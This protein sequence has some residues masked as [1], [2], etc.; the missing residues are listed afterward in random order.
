MIQDQRLNHYLTAW[1]LSTPQL[2]TQTVTSH[3]FTVIHDAETVILK[4]LSPC[5]TDEQRGALALRYF[6]GHG[7][8]RLLRHDNGAQLIEYASGV[9]LVTLVERGEDENATR[10]IAQVIQQLHSV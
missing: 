3:I 8:T 2:L 1:N 5:E 4:L 9:E 7:A 6:D 10:I